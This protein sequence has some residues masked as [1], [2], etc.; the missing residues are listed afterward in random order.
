MEETEVKFVLG[1]V[2][3]TY[4]EVAIS[5]F[6]AASK[7][8]SAKMKKMINAYAMSL[9]DMWERSF[10][11]KHVL[12]RQAVVERIQ[13][14]VS[15]YYTKVY[16]V[17]NRSSKKFVGEDSTSTRSIR[18]LNNEW[19]KTDIQ[20]TVN[21]RK[22]SFP[23]NSLFDI[24]KDKE[25][26]TGR[27]KC[28]YFDQKN[29]RKWGLS[30]EIDE[31]WVDEQ[32]ILQ[33]EAENEH[34]EIGEEDENDIHS[35]EED[36]QLNLDRSVNRSGLR[37]V[38]TEDASTQT[39]FGYID[40]PSIR[41]IRDCTPEIKQA[42][43][44]VS[45]K[46]NISTAM[47]TVAVQAV[48]EELYHHQYYLSKDEAIEKDP[49][50]QQYKQQPSEQQS[51]KRRLAE[52]KTATK[53]L[54]NK[55]DYIPYKDVLPSPR[56]LN[57]HKQLC[58][59]K[60]E[61]DAADALFNMDSAT[62]RCTLH[63][64]TTSRCQIDGEWPSIIFSFSDKQRYVLRPL[65][66]AYETRTQIVNLLLETLERLAV[67]VNKES[68]KTDAKTLWEKI[69]IIMTDS[70][71]KNLH[72]ENGIAAALGSS[73]IPLHLLCKA[74]TVEALDRS[75][76]N[77]L[78]QIEEA[79]KFRES[80]ESINPGL[81]SFLRGEKSVALCAIKS[82]LNFVSHDKSSSSTNQAELF[83]YVLQR[84]KKIKHLSLY[85]E[86]RFTKLGYSCS[87]ILDAMPYIQMVLNETNL[88]NLHTEIVQ[89]FLD[90]ELLIT[91]LTCLSYFT[92]KVSLP[93]LHA[94]E[95]CNQDELCQ[96]FPKLHQDLLNGCMDTLSEYTVHYKHLNIATPST[97]LD[98]EILRKMCI[99]AAE[100][101][102]RQ[103]GREYGFG[104]FQAETPRAT[105]VLHILLS[106]RPHISQQLVSN[107]HFC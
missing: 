81:K 17:A 12:R 61:S 13:K 67:L 44:K 99:D 90:S 86:R 10:T 6:S 54:S 82:I 52:P 39:T 14:L 34:L 56:T 53:P 21:R 89:L 76:I 40:K 91:E 32:L 22:I 93:L 100:T 41:G 66:F 105:Q 33:A 57:D 107:H 27:E 31:E 78:A 16:N 98:K 47:A 62:V 49:N 8:D 38:L 23:I 70:V 55:T 87:S 43:V 77:V 60:A 68:K 102:D 74:H 97:E 35:D 85:Q 65:F 75:N 63:Y 69:N 29:E 15:L 4:Y 92:H 50:L 51:K 103:C 46:C 18:S 95:V 84:E 5:I 25:L 104:K 24:I 101:I 36:S 26:L 42:C 71:E 58:A 45:V 79:V 3:P 106:F 1:D 72:I 88:S 94:V 28:F 11:A 30:E 73:H 80:L 48:C 19:K 7:P 20:F 37:R 59:I 64:D 9:L 2:L 83:D 96:I